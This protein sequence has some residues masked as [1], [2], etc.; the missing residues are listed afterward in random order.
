MS[1]ISVDN[2]GCEFGY[3]LIMCVPFAYHHKSL[4][5]N[6]VVN[7]CKGM[8][9]FYYFLEDNEFVEK[10]DK[11][12]Y[13]TPLGT[14]LRTIHFNNLDTQE[15]KGPDYKNY[16]GKYDLKSNFKKE[17]LIISNKYTSEWGGHPVNY[18][19][20][21][22]LDELFDILSSRYDIV[23]NRPRPSNICNDEAEQPSMILGDQTI[24][25]NHK[26]VYDINDILEKEDFDFN[27]LQLILMSKAKNKISVQGGTSIISS[28]LGGMNKVYAIK[29]GELEHNSFKGWYGKFSGCSVNDFQTYQSL[30]DS[31]KEDYL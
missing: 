17:L 20:L 18:L 26:N 12:R 29:G 24:I 27:T 28:F 5:N 30:I 21:E 31:V 2:M 15:F 10:Y 25:D 7:S 14:R 4:K 1:K 13:A 22:C 23:Y 8:R 11:R 9:P 6:I 19:S 3:E 16:Y